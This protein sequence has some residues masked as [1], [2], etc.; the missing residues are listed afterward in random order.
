MHNISIRRIVNIAFMILLIILSGTLAILY[1]TK[2]E[3]KITPTRT[4][5]VVETRVVTNYVFTSTLTSPPYQTGLHAQGNN[6]FI[7]AFSE[8][9]S[10]N[11]AASIADITDIAKFREVCHETERGT[12][13]NNWD[14][15]KRQLMNDDIEIGIDP[16]ASMTDK[17]PYP[18]VSTITTESGFPLVYLTQQQG[19][20]NRHFTLPLS[21][22]VTVVFSFMICC[23]GSGT[24]HMLESVD[25]Y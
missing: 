21:H 12:C 11:D 19:F 14:T 20:D 2:P 22:Y 10:Y 7:K 8:A 25:L 24:T 3:T 5:R 4:V 18:D 17:P 13:N 9:L 23:G 16:Y 1:V 15:F 6:I